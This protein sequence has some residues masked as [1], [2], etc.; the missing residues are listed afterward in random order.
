MRDHVG[1]T[2]NKPAP[3][4]PFA[5]GLGPG[6]QVGR[7]LLQSRL[8]SGGMADVWLATAKGASGFQKT[9]VLK[10]ILPRLADNPEF[11]KM[12]INEALLA[13]ALE[14]P[15]IV[16][17]FDLGQAGDAYYIAMEYIAGRTLRQVQRALRNKERRV[18]PPWFVLSVASSVCDAL[19]YA[20]NRRDDSGKPLNIVHRDVT[21]ENI[22][23]AFTGDIKVLDFGIAK[24]STAATQTQV[25]TLKGK[26]AYMA[27]E[28]VA[29]AAR[30]GAPADPRFDIYALGVLLYECLTGVRPFRAGNELMLLR[31]ILEE[32]PEPPSKRASWI[33][34]ALERIIMTAMARDPAERYQSAEL[35]RHAVDDYLTGRRMYPTRHH[36]AEYV[37]KLFEQPLGELSPSSAGVEDAGSGYRAPSSV[38]MEEARTGDVDGPDSIEIV[39]SEAAQNPG[40]AARRPTSPPTPEGTVQQPDQTAKARNEDSKQKPRPATVRAAA[41]AAPLV[42]EPTSGLR[43]VQV[44]APASPPAG[45]VPPRAPA[46]PLA[47]TAGTPAPA[48]PAARG[49]TPAGELGTKPSAG[50]SPRPPAPQG[51]AVVVP[52]PPPPAVA[53]PQ[54][55]GGPKAAPAAAAVTA[56]PSPATPGPPPAPKP[57]TTGAAPKPASAGAKG[58][59][60]VSVPKPSTPGPKAEVPV[61]VPKPATAAPVVA[62]Q[63][64]APKP[65]APAPMADF[66]VPIPKPSTAGVR[67]ATP[68]SVPKPTT[69][70]AKT[71][72]PAAVAKPSAPGPSADVPLPVAKPATT[73]HAEP[74]LAGTPKPP[75][76]TTGGVPLVSKPATA[77]VRTGGGL[78][79]A[80]AGTAAR[81]TAVADVATPIPS[82][83]AD[84]PLQRERG[85]PQRSG[86][87]T[88]AWDR[89]TQRARQEREAM[90]QEGEER[91]SSAETPEPPGSAEDPDAA[92]PRMSLTPHAWDAL[93]QRTRREVEQESERDP[94]PA[95]RRSAGSVGRAAEQGPDKSV[96]RS[97]AAELRASRLFEEGLE[98]MRARDYQAAL[99]AWNEALVHD[100]TNRT[101][102]SNLRTLNRI[103]SGGKK[104]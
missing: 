61:A 45:P 59:A 39:F 86:A 13:A 30:A 11:V 58:D 98:R 38:S 55:S 20:H 94:R 90:E 75:S 35:L 50:V 3:S 12:F 104:P 89:L 67:V 24:A 91:V 26:F 53:A 88:A 40:E 47:P 15:N 9:V 92:E 78:A 95:A 37:C 93:V 80:K 4:G 5:D 19:H 8:A 36:V 60:Q 83:P 41:A 23:I 73:R 21:P 62:M 32:E 51:G 29:G 70:G 22:M 85:A 57:Q 1:D 79:V 48:P 82:A 101:I 84:S 96:R 28:Q 52:P 2:L 54:R 31:Q 68:L 97:A 72:A 65:S 27:P 103:I 25:G 34:K 33:P 42:V 87:V 81:K 71:E 44:T 102:Q 100:P 6:V 18:P 7:Y 49:S 14:H 16:H 17:I 64:V 10:T 63:P 56:G 46:L 69:A 43:Q 76:S 77:G 66:A 74:A 99:R